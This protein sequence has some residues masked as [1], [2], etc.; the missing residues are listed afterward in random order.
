MR[1][2]IGAGLLRPD[3]AGARVAE[4]GS[5]GRTGRSGAEE[6][7][8]RIVTLVLAAMLGC[9][10]AAGLAQ[11]QAPLLP[12]AGA[13]PAPETRWSFRRVDDGFVRLDNKTGRIA[14]C[15]PV[16]AG[17][18][19]QAVPEDRAALEQQIARLQDDVAALNKQ[20][21]ELRAAPPPPPEK[22]LDVSIRMPTQQEIARARDY[23]ADTLTDTWRRLVQMIVRFQHDLLRKS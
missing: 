11:E 1:W 16:H 4:R 14:H 22:G 21:A 5:G 8:L 7:T 10:A 12:P 19:C 2:V 20:I 18:A 9:G 13:P 17:W 15:T 6:K 23:L 3:L